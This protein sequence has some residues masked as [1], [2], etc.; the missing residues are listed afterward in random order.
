MESVPCGGKIIN[1]RLGNEMRKIQNSSC[2]G[3]G[4]KK[5]TMSRLKPHGIP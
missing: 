4:A 3:R 2:H 1:F 5:K